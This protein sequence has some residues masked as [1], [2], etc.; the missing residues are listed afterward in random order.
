MYFENVV[1]LQIYGLCCIYNGRM[2][3]RM[4]VS[5]GGC[6]GSLNIIGAFQRN[7]SQSHYGLNGLHATSLSLKESF[8]VPLIFS[9]SSELIVLSTRFNFV[10]RS[11]NKAAHAMAAEGSP[12]FSD[13]F[14][15]ENAP[16]HVFTVIDEDRQ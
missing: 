3:C 14:W 9:P 7:S 11:G 16:S 12:Y 6:I 5:L 4:L 1:M 2:K 8:K 10:P 15:I 13:E